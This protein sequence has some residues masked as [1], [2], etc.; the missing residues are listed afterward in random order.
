[1]KCRHHEAQARAESSIRGK[2]FHKPIG[3]K[4]FFHF[5]SGAFGS[6][7]HAAVTGQFK[8]GSVGLGRDQG[9]VI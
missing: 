9:P 3:K 7:I 2:D 8:L 5:S 4:L 1:M 6:P